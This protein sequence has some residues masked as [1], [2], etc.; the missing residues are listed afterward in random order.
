MVSAK[1]SILNSLSLKLYSDREFFI[2][3]L[4]GMGTMDL[5]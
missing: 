4:H 1:A 3:Y 5:A 2:I